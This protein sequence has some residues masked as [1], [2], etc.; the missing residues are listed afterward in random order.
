MF[1]RTRSVYARLLCV[2]VLLAA[3]VGAHAARVDITDPTLLGDIVLSIDRGQSEY[4]ES[5]VT[6]VR[7]AN[8]LYS[9]IYA[10]QSGR[11]FPAGDS[12]PRL[13]SYSIT[14]R[15]LEETW[16]AIQSSDEF[17]RG[18]YAV[19]PTAAVSRID[20]IHDGFIVF[21]VGAF[22]GQFVVVYVQ[23]QLPPVLRGLL[24]YTAY[25][26]EFDFETGE[27][28]RNYGSY[29]KGGFLVPTPE[30]GSVILFATGLAAIVMNRRRRRHP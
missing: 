24:T 25:N 2:A 26:T 18:D 8:G 30:P 22:E 17:W 1:T 4:E 9:Y 12:D 5:Q 15:P 7:F 10:I 19:N 21:P 23:S 16:G 3:P 28:V 20:R 27:Y 29:S 6:E 13:V 11:Y 14:G